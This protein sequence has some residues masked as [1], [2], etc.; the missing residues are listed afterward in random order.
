MAKRKRMHY[1]NGKHNKFAYDNMTRKLKVHLFESIKVI[2]NE[3]LREDEVENPKK[4]SKKR[5][6]RGPF[7]V[8]I[9]QKIIRETS[10]KK[11]F[12][13]LE[14][15]IKDIFMNVSKKY[16]KYNNEELIKKFIN[17]ETKTSKILKR[18]FL[19]CLKHFRGSEKIEELAGLENGYNNVIDELRN[20]GEKEENIENFKKFVEGFEENIKL[21]NK[22]VV[23]KKIK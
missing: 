8:K 20:K 18:S 21:K 17:K 14:A 4:N 5:I 2:L 9:N 3:S 12:L 15:K 13:L 10:V 7:F 6:V 22:R 1:I 16:N 23:E 11:N 19:E